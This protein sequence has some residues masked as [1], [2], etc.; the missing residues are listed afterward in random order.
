[1]QIMYYVLIPLVAFVLSKLNKWWQIELVAV[2]SVFCILFK[3]EKETLLRVSSASVDL[4]FGQCLPIF[5]LGSLVAYFF[6]RADDMG[7]CD[8]VRNSN[9]LSSL[10]CV[11]NFALMILGIRM[12]FIY[13]LKRNLLH[14]Y[15]NALFW[16]FSLF[17]MLIGEPNGEP[18]LFTKWL[19][20]IHFL[21]TLGKFSFGFYLFHNVALYL[22]TRM[23]LPKRRFSMEDKLIVAILI[24]FAFGWVFHHCIEKPMIRIAY[25]VNKRF[26]GNWGLKQSIQIN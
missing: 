22:A 16:S 4:T 24:A 25:H 18:N 8:S 11:L 20:E 10:V 17:L 3:L 12:S 6:K 15:N 14:S 26:I 13:P 23:D 1:M 9:L 5:A 2:V 21:R 19:T 7:I